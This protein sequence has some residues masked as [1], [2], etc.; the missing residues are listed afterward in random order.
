MNFK[1][2]GWLLIFFI[3]SCGEEKLDL[4]P[5]EDGK[6]GVG[7]ITRTF[8]DTSR[9]TPSAGSFPEETSRTLVT[10]IWYPSI[11]GTSSEP[12]RN[13]APELREA[14]YPLIIFAHGAMSFRTQSTFL[15]KHLA[16]HG[17]V[18]FSPDFPLSSFKK[19]ANMN[20]ADV[21]NQSRDVSFLITKALEMSRTEGDILYNMI[22]SE[23]IGVTG[24]SLGGLTSILAGFYE[25][26]KDERIRAVAPISP[27]ACFLK[28]EV[29]EGK[30]LPFLIIGG[31]KDMFVSFDTNIERIYEYAEAPKFMI[32]LKNGTHL[33]SLDL[34]I[35]E[36]FA[37]TIFSTFMKA[38]AT[39]EA[40]NSFYQFLNTI[41]DLSQC[42]NLY[43]NYIENQNI[44]FVVGYPKDFMLP[45]RQRNYEKAFVLAFFNLYLKGYEGWK[46][47]LSEEYGKKFKD[48]IIKSSQ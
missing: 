10:E 22:S 36:T 33:G 47:F 37:F 48:V 2:K 12:V 3:F 18:V 31:D 40:E 4:T 34:D 27:F 43:E 39:E 8:Y 32:L 44:N 28:K 17:Y 35:S 15:C 11:E 29:F 30:S 24:H 42:E 6:F 45:E 7:V 20:P 38:M 25:G 9:K 23:K 5:F 46:K 21:I 26:L 1:N 19:F 16:S 14:P 13:G 41:G